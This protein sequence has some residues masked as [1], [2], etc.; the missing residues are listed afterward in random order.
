MWASPAATVMM[1]E[2]VGVVEGMR[3]REAVL[4]PVPVFEGVGGMRV[5]EAVLLPVGVFEGVGGMQPVSTADPAYPEAPLVVGF[6]GP[7]V[8]LLTVT[9]ACE[10]EDPPPPPP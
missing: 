1:P 9:E 7:F 10:N 5:R 4:L 2:R 6:A 3:V 8:G